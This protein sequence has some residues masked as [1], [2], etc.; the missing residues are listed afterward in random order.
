LH[1][2]VSSALKT[3]NIQNVSRRVGHRS[4]V[5]TRTKCVPQNTD[6]FNSVI[7]LSDIELYQL[8]QHNFSVKFISISFK[9]CNW[10]KCS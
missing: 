1:F 3:L 4:E 2:V 9:V 10:I 5:V 8:I 6:R 7:E